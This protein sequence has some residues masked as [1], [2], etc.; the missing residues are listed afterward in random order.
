[1]P[2]EAGDPALGEVPKADRAIAAG[3]GEHVPVLERDGVD[4]I[5]VP[6]Q[7]AGWVPLGETFHTRTVLSSLAV[8]TRLPPGL[9]ATSLIA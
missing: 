1:V 7:G 3:A 6:Q 4:R 9:N 5:R 8:A 2:G